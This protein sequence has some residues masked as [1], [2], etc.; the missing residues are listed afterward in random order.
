VVGLSGS[1]TALAA[2]GGHTCALTSGGGVKCWGENSGGQLG[3]GT[4]ARSSS[5]V[6]VTGL[7]SGVTAIAAGVGH[8]CALTSGGGVKCWGHN[9]SGQL[10]DGKRT[11]SSTPVAV[12]NLASDVT[13]VTAGGNHTCALTARGGVTCWGSNHYGQLGAATALATGMRAISAGDYHTCGL[14]SGGEVRCWGTNSSG[15]LGNGTTAKSSVPVGPF[16]LAGG[17]T[18]VAAGGARTCAITG[19]GGVKC[20]GSGSSVQFVGG[21]K[22]DNTRPT[23]VDFSIHQTITL[24][25]P[26]PAARVPAGSTVTFTAT[27]APPAPAGARATVQFSFRRA[28]HGRLVVVARRDVRVAANG[29]ATLKWTSSSIGQWFFVRAWAMPNES[30][31]A[32]GWSRE[33]AVKVVAVR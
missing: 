14:T 1:V 3:N 28:V 27:V 33:F 21:P 24:Q 7:S 18:A 19:A 23:D 13:A 31:P 20:W 22:A 29:Q 9:T 32:S 30:Q 16:G 10:G 15:Q 26:T 2:G 11:D 5:P 4:T 25:R 6:E 17:V 12:A 8:T